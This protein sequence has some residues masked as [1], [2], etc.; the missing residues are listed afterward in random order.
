LWYGCVHDIVRSIFVCLAI[1]FVACTERT[2]M[3]TQTPPLHI[4]ATADNLRELVTNG[5]LTQ[6]AL[7]RALI[8]IG[9]IP[10]THRW[11][12]FL[13]VAL[14]VLGSVFTLS[15]VVFFFAYNWSALPPFFKFGLIVV[16]TAGLIR[17][18]FSGIFGDSWAFGAF[19][20]G[21]AIIAQITV[22]FHW[23]RNAANSR[24]YQR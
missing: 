21:A 23:L 24:E 12:A 17:F 14:M 9:H 5:Q 16:I 6:A 15:G 7:E 4:E 22:A 1:C 8:L 10:S 11:R 3:Q 19:C 18:L 13:N 2:P 20:F